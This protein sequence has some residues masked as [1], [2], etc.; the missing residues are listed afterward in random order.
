MKLVEEILIAPVVVT[1]RVIVMFSVCTGDAV[2]VVD[3][4][5]SRGTS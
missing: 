4:A 1:V 5:R 2:D 3:E